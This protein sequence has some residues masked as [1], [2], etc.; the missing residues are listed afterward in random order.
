MSED[1]K[2][3]EGGAYEV[4][5]A[6][7]LTQSED[8][9]QRLDALNTQRKDIFGAVESALVSTE[10]ITTEHNCTPRDMI[11]IGNNRFFFGYNIQFG[12]KQTTDP[13]DVFDAYRYEPS[14]HTFHKL[15]LDEV[16]DSRSFR[17]DFA[18]LYKYYRETVFAKFMR[19]GP[20][21]Y[22]ALRVGKS[23][24]DIKTFKFLIK[25]DGTL[26][27]QGNRSDHE[28]T[29]PD[30]HEFTWQRA[31]RDMQRPG[32]H[33]HLS[34]EDRVFV[35]TV[36]GDLTIKVEDNTTDGLGIYQEPV[37]DHDQTLD[38]AEIEYAIVG[39]LILLKILPYR[40]EK[41]RYLVF[42]EKTQSV[43]RIDAIGESCV[44][45]PDDHGIIFANG[46]YLLSGE[47]KTF[48]HGLEHMRFER[49]ISSANGEDTLYA[50]YNR[51]SGDYVL[52]NY[53]LIERN[54][55]PP[56]VCNGYSIFDNGELLYFKTE[57]EAQKHH[58]IQVWQTPI[59]SDD[60][61]ISQQQ[62]QDSYLFKIGNAELVR[63]M[64]EC[65]ELIT[66]LHKDD[67]YAGLYIDLAKLSGDLLDSY[68]WI[69]QEEAGALA[70][71]IAG[72]KQAAESAISEFDK[73]QRLRNSAAER[74]EDLTERTGKQVRAA[75]NSPPDDILGF[76]RQLAGLRALRGEV[77]GLREMRYMDLE[78]VDGL[79]ESIAT[80]ADSVSEK[81]VAFLLQPEALD[82]YRA[83]VDEH[84]KVLEQ[85]G[86]VTE[87]E[88]LGEAISATGQELE[89]LIDV[90]S[91]L[92]IEDSTQTTTIIESISDIY[93]V[94]NGAKAELKNKR[95]SLAQG[96]AVAQFGAQ[97]KLLGQAVVNYL[98]LC[99][100]PEKTEEYLTKV[101]VQIEELEGRFSEFDDYV[102]ELSAKREEVYNAFEGRKQQLL[103]TR[104]KR[105]NTLVKSAQRVLAG[106]DN[107][108]S[109]F[110]E[111][112]EINGYF[113]DDLMIEKVR[114]IITQ[115]TELG[116]SVK[117][118]DIQ[119]R[120][121]T[122]REDAVRALKDRNELFVDGT[123]VL[124]FGKHQ[125]NVN[126][127]PLQ[128]TIVPQD[129]EMCFHLAG[130]DFFEPIRDEA[131]LATRD[132]WQQEVVSENDEVYRAEFLA[133]EFLKNH[134]MDELEEL[135]ANGLLPAVQKFMQPRYAEN[136]T[137]GV[138]DLDAHKLLE[139]IIPIHGKIGLLRFSPETRA[140]AQV[141]WLSWHGDEKST[142]ARQI[143]AYAK[144]REIFGDNSSERHTL[145]GPLESAISEW[146]GTRAFHTA[147][148]DSAA[149]YLF[150]EL[151][152]NEHFIVSPDAAELV[153]KFKH[154]L[155]VKHAEAS[156]DESLQDI[157]LPLDR[158]TTL[159]DW[160]AGF[161]RSQ[162]DAEIPAAVIAEAAAHLTRGGFD[163]RDIH[164][165]RTRVQIDGLI[166]DHDV[167]N[168]GAYQL[169]YNAFRD[170]M[171]NFERVGVPTFQAYQEL[172][173]RLVEEKREEMRLS[174]FEPKVMSAFVRNKLLNNVFL[175]IVGDNLAKQLGT[176]G[177]DTRTDRMG[178]LL[179]ISPPGYGKTTLM[180][181]VANRL[182]LT[183]MKING[184][185]LGHNVVSLDPAE[186]PNAAARE[187]VIKLNL[188]LEMGDNVM[189]YLDDIQHT[190]SEFLQKFI[191]LCDAQRKIEG[192]YQGKARTYDLRGKKVAVVMAGN[193]YTET[194]GKFQ[195]PD[196]LANRADTYNLGDIIGG[197]AN[198]FKAS[199]IENALTSNPIL[200]KLSSRSQKD[201]YAIMRIADTGSQE[202]ID[203]EGNY[204]PAE[205]DEM[206]RVVQHLSRVRDSILRV[207]LEYI[208]SAAQEDAYRTEP[209]FKL[210]GSY[211]NMNR[212]AEKV[213]P[214]MT[215]EEVV[216]LITD[217]Y[218]NESQTLTTGAESNMLKFR[219][220]ENMLTETQAA[221]WAE[222]KKGF[223]K[224][225]LLGAGG[226]NDPVARVVAQMS[227]FNDGLNAIQLGIA[228][229]AA[230]KSSPQTLER[231]TLAQLKALIEGL[232]AVPVK[233]D[234]NLV[235]T[236][237]D[238]DDDPTITDME[239]SSRS[240]K[241]PIDIEPKVTQGDPPA[242]D[243]T[244]E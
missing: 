182:G 67:N 55:Q 236:S 25:S 28:Y 49:K 53:N 81:T 79:E 195:I 168:A 3:L 207:N 93:S 13:E 211:R 150:E 217:H 30:Q 36:G 54:V 244:K 77:I 135:L 60:A 14:D 66:L 198:D 118:D 58:V 76:V 230:A 82:P 130:T 105:V 8:L 143:Q 18:Y 29:F 110:K 170:R 43:N 6:R 196:M 169:D 31:T 162:D 175:P 137:K 141:F 161:A 64:A 87:A 221:R 210:Q 215:D 61:V 32:E 57:L 242:S 42:N 180:E 218:E 91:N 62:S 200:N 99:D 134:R 231:E 38:D 214:L 171:E 48:D 139:A 45:L 20:V 41:V 98:D 174:E 109:N 21:L 166:G 34:I 16:I 123:N 12:L 73:V 33:P 173:Q 219:E 203:F 47:L 39:P 235:P 181:Y 26:E 145:V 226:E 69:E 126:T 74:I 84:R 106:I 83:Q 241:P 107:R 75:E 112:N 184:P 238:D 243:D 185:A 56:V 17:E 114:D 80:T 23:I 88:E 129:E 149:L 216:G 142:L 187:E 9:G 239:K 19:K 159:K 147:R 193:P 22:L 4:I 127:Q 234:I 97:L 71:P 2:Q 59:L 51:T 172:K 183:F 65:R 101:M 228:Q 191:S 223:N 96:E 7:L 40:E 11:S 209:A 52:L 63:A 133:W 229:A 192:V 86:K 201:V 146:T 70:K 128:L 158:F 46:Y 206:V 212:I 164:Q 186:A 202:G 138:H 232:R 199:Y 205:I 15:S 78:R 190:H 94:L 104:N 122:I 68:F 103:E 85:L 24:D 50:F 151:A 177:K 100:T 227:E 220:M 189:I 131:F 117:A 194:G 132:V 176:A 178:L 102:E 90:V 160:L 121:K 140:L 155:V 148:P 233:V 167:V 119:T 165:V 37:E 120:L 222:I 152:R 136:Y 111:I 156:F 208:R 92:K 10:R 27:Y 125:F 124:R 44:L 116:D 5:R 154:Q 153:K 72:I 163:L 213:L 144:R 237:G 224:N 113:A 204:T 179:L 89:M 108:I 240:A 115:L 95:K 197:H 188:A 1:S 157:E 35:E 225:K